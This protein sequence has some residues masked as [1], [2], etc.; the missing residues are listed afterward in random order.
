MATMVTKKTKRGK[1]GKVDNQLQM[2]STG[3]NKGGISQFRKKWDGFIDTKDLEIVKHVNSVFEHYQGDEKFFGTFTNLATKLV[4]ADDADK[5]IHDF[6]EEEKFENMERRKTI[7][8]LRA[9][10]I[11][12]SEITSSLHH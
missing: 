4:A 7:N 8:W 5:F 1:K 6:F 12:K 11:R 9:F 2:N 10:H 3:S